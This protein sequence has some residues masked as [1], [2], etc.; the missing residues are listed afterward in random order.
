VSGDAIL[1][2][3]CNAVNTTLTELTLTEMGLVSHL[4]IVALAKAHPALT[5]LD[6]SG[7]VGVTDWSVQAIFK[8]QVKFNVLK[9]FFILL[10]FIW[11]GK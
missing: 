5:H 8:Y 2:S 6:L 3:L 1:K 4:H 9:L 11:L 7:C 10:D